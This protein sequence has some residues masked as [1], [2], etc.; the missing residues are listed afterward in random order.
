MKKQSFWN[1]NEKDHITNR[2]DKFMTKKE[3]KI[4]IIY[5]FLIKVSLV[6]IFDIYVVAIH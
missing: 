4:I 5:H 1:K 6:L 2:Y 3:K